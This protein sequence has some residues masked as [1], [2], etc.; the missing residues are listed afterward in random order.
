MVLLSSM[1]SAC[2]LMGAGSGE[3]EKT[4]LRKIAVLPVAYSDGMGGGYACDLC[5]PAVQMKPTNAQAARLATAFLYE[6]TARHPRI[7]KPEF[8]V[9]EPVARKGMRQAANELA[10]AGQADAVLVGALVELRARVGSD[11]GPETPAGAVMYAALVDARTGATLWSSTFDANETGPGMLRSR[12]Q[13]LT[14]A[15]TPRWRTAEGYT[16]V[17]AKELVDGLMD[18]LGG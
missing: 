15:K 3:D 5:P 16:E 7:L 13:R 1:L 11:H 6:E 2:T 12:L 9:V 8:E 4:G 10:A 18:H 17:A 14:G